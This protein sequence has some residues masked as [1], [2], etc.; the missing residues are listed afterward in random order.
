MR[1]AVLADI[2]KGHLGIYKCHER[3]KSAVYW[4]GY[5]GQISDMVESCSACQE[6]MRANAKTML[7]PYGIPN[8]PMQT[9]SVDIFHLDGNNFLVTVDRFS[10]WPS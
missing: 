10:K 4:P 1:K 3:A 7:E 8:Y 2:H 5:H 6:N 9:I